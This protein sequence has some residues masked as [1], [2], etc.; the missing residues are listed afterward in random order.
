M[1]RRKVSGSIVKIIAVQLIDKVDQSYVT[2]CSTFRRVAYGH[3]YTRLYLT[4]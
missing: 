2:R 3:A 4:E 1:L